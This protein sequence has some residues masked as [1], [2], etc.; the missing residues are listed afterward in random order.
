MDGIQEKEMLNFIYSIF[1]PQANI[2]KEIKKSRTR[3]LYHLL[4]P[5]YY[6]Q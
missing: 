1:N 3:S 6:Q 2:E 5:T 4:M